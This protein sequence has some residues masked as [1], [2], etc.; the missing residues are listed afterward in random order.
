MLPEPRRIRPLSD[1]VINQIAAGEVIERPASVVKELVENS[2][3]AGA[4]QVEV[5][6]ED[7]GLLSIVVRDNGDGLAPED[8][9]AALRRHWTSKLSESSE[10]A[11]IATLGFRGEALASI[12]AVAQLEIVSRQPGQA[13]GWRVTASPGQE[14]S[15]PVPHQGPPGTRI[16]VR[17]LFYNVPARKRFLKR[18]RT[19]YLH[20]QQLVR[21]LGFAVP[22]LDLALI[23]AGSRGV[24]LRAARADEPMQRWRA[25]FGAALLER[26]TRVSETAG[27]LRISGWLGASELAS[28]Q[29][30]VQFLAL[31]GRPIRDR[32]L[33]HAV[34]QAYGERL[35]PG[36]FPVYALA[37]ETPLTDA[38]VNVHPGKLEV[39]F[40]DLRMVH[41]FVHGV[42]R[43]TLD[44]G[45]AVLTGSP[46]PTT[47]AVR[48]AQAGYRS[49]SGPAA[50]RAM[51]PLSSYRPA[52]AMGAVQLGQLLALVESRYLLTLKDGAVFALDLQAAWVA[53]LSRRLGMVPAASRPLLTP[54]RVT[55]APASTLE[56]H[57][58]GLI[59]S[60]FEFDELGPTGFVLRGLPA[61]FPAVPAGALI[62]RLAED[63]ANSSDLL[64]ATARAAAA[65]LVYGEGGRPNSALVDQ[66]KLGASAANVALE[67][68]L[69]PLSG[70][71]LGAPPH[72]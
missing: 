16:T 22:A 8:M 11:A 18:G 44:G 23:Q 19:E 4:T 30:D 52:Q 20:V 50:T 33:A 67:P 12:A 71:N 60:G 14:P 61:V 45:D 31:N 48:E 5:E 9:P 17:E 41:D 40:V 49:G 55:V 38:D 54:E 21:R 70:A 65:V 39:R 3:D 46:T 62:M 29:S 7:G 27:A 51:S 25:L 53:V 36:R 1:Y 68:L 28:S 24:R 66:L 58:P 34:R 32:Q 56:R 69:V 43:Q 15:A 10:L 42:V 57:R 72:G 35:A 37:L 59:A 26:A 64:F 47:A 13:H 63:L 2:I 6:L